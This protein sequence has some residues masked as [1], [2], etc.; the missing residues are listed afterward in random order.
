MNRRILP[1]VPHAQTL[2]FSIG[3]ALIFYVRNLNNPSTNEDKFIGKVLNFTHGDSFKDQL[4]PPRT[5]NSPLMNTINFVS[6]YLTGRK[7]LRDDKFKWLTCAIEV[8]NYCKSC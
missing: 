4:S 8:N 3:L 1:V 2:L 7:L 5:F 6:Q